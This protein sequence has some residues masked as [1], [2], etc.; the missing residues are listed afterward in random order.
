MNP[1]NHQDD[2]RLTAYALGE[3]SASEREQLEAI[4]R[5]DDSA[6]QI[7]EEIR[8]TAGLLSSELASQKSDAGLTEAQRETIA[9]NPTQPRRSPRARFVTYLASGLAAAAVVALATAIFLPSLN[10]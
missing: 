9:P 1:I 5:D 7:V 6:R 10:R 4:L 3:L 2:P 8:A